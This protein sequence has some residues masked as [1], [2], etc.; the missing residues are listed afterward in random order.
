MKTQEICGRL[1]TVTDGYLTCPVCRRNRRLMKIYPD[2][3][4]TGVIAY[5]RDCKTENRIDIH[6]GRC[7]ESRSR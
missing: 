3:E 4:A 7:Y 1:L 2:T 6:D 5:C